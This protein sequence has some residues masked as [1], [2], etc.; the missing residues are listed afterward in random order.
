MKKRIP[1]IVLA[2]ILAA[3]LVV[4]IVLAVQGFDFTNTV[5]SL[6]PPVAA[7]LLALITKEVYSSLFIG[8]LIG[9]LLYSGYNI[10]GAVE[11][12]FLTGIIGTYN[13]TGVTAGALSDPWNIGILIFLVILGVMVQLMNAA[14]GS[15]AFGK[16]SNENIK[17]RVTAQLSVVALGCLIFIDDFQL[18]DRRLRYASHR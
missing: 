15:A 4:S 6:L 10:I 5:W 3:L 14:G 16:W 12:I 7:I 13:D 2:V 17:S 1:L 9:G 11:H 18:P 8:I